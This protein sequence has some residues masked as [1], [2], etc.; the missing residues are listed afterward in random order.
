VSDAIGE[1]VRWLDAQPAS[2]REIVFAGIL[3]RGSIDAVNIEQVP[4]GIGVRFAPATPEPQT[5]P[6]ASL[7]TIRDGALTRIDRELVLTSDATQIGEQREARVAPDLVT[8]VAP[9]EHRRLAAAALRAVLGEGLPWADFDQR[10]VVAWDRVDA[11]SPGALVVRMPVPQPAS[12]A[13]DALRSALILQTARQALKEPI[14]ISDAQ[15]QQW[16]RQPGAVSPQAPLTDEGDRRW[17]WAV[18]LILLFVEWWMRR[19]QAPATA[20]VAEEA[21]VA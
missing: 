15:L 7:L 18:A 20:A 2:A 14:A 9:E 17:L 11:G 3:R 4:A 8:I 10:V 1:A 19:S 6:T 5:T 16:A 13:A 21:R 12:S